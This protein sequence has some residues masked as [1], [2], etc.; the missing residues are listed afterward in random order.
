MLLKNIQ[1]KN[2]KKVKGNRILVQLP[3]GL[4]QYS[5]ELMEKLDKQFKGKKQLFLLVEPT[6]GACDLAEEKALSLN[7]QTIIH[8]GHEKF[9]KPKVRTIYIPIKIPLNNKRIVKLVLEKLETKNFNTIVIAGLQQFSFNLK[10][11]KKLLE[12]EKI[13][14]LK[15]GTVLGCNYEWLVKAEK[16]V[17]CIVFIGEG[18]F[19]LNGL[20]LETVKPVLFVNAL[21][22]EGKWFQELRREQLVRQKWARIALAKQAKTFGLIVSTKKGQ[23]LLI[24]ALKAKKLIE[25][26]GLKAVLLASDLIKPENFLGLKIDCFVNTACPRIAVDDYQQ[27]NAPVINLKDLKEVL[28]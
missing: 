18:S 24:Q 4:K 13:K 3:D 8:F 20:L 12:K 26:K 19:H 17:K 28:N 23:L 1:W 10:E 21:G 11:L 9:Y 16:K 5:L 22:L 15:T 7:C 14:V 27:F 6:F 25:K 2:L